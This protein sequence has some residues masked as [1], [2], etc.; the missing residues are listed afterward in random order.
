MP[1]TQV[2][3]ILL[4]DLPVALWRE[5]AAHHELVRESLAEHRTKAAPKRLLALHDRLEADAGEVAAPSELELR[6]AAE[7]RLKEVDVAY[8]IPRCARD[9]LE[10]LGPAWDAVD[11]F[12]RRQKRP[13]L[14]TPPHCVAFR[15]WM[16]GELVNQL[17]GGFPTPWKG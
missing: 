3:D 13:D 5:T 15:R 9:G 8:G 10:A 17:D 7:R 6:A 1:G 14:V 11:A 16:L 2:V 12:W 4:L